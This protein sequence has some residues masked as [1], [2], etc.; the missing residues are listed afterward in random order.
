[1]KSYVVGFL[2]DEDREEVVLVRKNRPAWQ[3]G[4]YNGVGGK[5]EI[6]EEPADAMVREFM[7]ET[8]VTITDW[9]HFLTLNGDDGS[10]DPKPDS[11][12]T[13]HFFSAEQ[14]KLHGLVQTMTDEEICVVPLRKI[15]AHNAVPNLAWILPLALTEGPKL[16]AT[17]VRS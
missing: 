5:I 17:E 11:L 8:G 4:L 3:A 7:E 9:A 10:Y 14:P 12:F 1:M 13:V 2:F 6:G 15:G 16:I